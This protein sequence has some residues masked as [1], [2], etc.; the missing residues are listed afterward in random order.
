MVK[1]ALHR[2]LSVVTVAFSAMKAAESKEQHNT[3]G[4]IM[5]LMK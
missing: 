3:I 4:T 1:N 2:A 5:S